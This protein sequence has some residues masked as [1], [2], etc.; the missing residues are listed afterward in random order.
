[1]SLL[2]H[3]RVYNEEGKYGEVTCPSG[4]EEDFLVML[5]QVNSYRCVETLGG[6]WT[7]PE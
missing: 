6:Y 3:P 7:L 1:M 2:Q 4:S 5:S